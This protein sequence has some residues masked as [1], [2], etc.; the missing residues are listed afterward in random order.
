MYKVSYD[1]QTNIKKS[2]RKAY[3]RAFIRLQT[4]DIDF[5]SCYAIQRYLSD[6]PTHIIGVIG[7]MYD[8][9]C[10]F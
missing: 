2:F 4:A 5:A 9:C 1:V 3:G 8:N 10:S 6:T 7:H